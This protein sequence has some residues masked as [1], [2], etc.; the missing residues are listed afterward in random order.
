MIKNKL[1]IGLI[2]LSSIALAQE[3]LVTQYPEELYQYNGIGNMGGTAR[4]QGMSGA[5]GALGGDLSAVS[6]NPAGAAVFLNSEGTLTAG[7]NI[8]KTD[9]GNNNGNKFSDS[10]F[11]LDQAGAVLVFNQMNSNDWRNVAISMN[12]QRQNTI[13]EL[14]DI[15]ADMSLVDVNGNYVKNYKSA[16]SGNSSMT[17]INV[18]ANYQDKFYFG[19]GINFHTFESS[20]YESLTLHEAIYDDNFTYVKDYTP[21]SRLGQGISAGLGVIGKVNQ[22]LRLGLAYLSPTWYVDTEELVREYAMYSSTDDQGDYYYIAG[23]DLLFVNDLTTSHKFTGSAALVLGK[24]GLISADY[25]YTDYSPA[26]YKPEADFAG[27]N[28]FIENEMNGTSTIRVGAEGRFNDFRVRGGFRY[29][30]SPFEDTDINGN[31]LKYQP[32]GNLTGFSLGA[33]YEFNSMFIDAA[34]NFY[35]RDRQYLIAGNF[36]DNGASVDAA[37]ITEDD[38]LDALSFN[39]AEMGYESVVKDITEQQG[40]ISLT[41]GFRF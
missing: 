11:N 30:Q 24:N 15:E 5:M 27:E 35:Q 41:V 18:A 36:Y 26:K 6:V 1:I 17:N 9:L 28:R 2:G 25:T 10:K 4:F 23:E 39:A 16:R 29:E 13:N 12:Y 37:G 21:N 14:A 40:N 22:N 32:F 3:S 20:N 33:G 7:V 19:G 38:A 31:G 8:A 34:Y